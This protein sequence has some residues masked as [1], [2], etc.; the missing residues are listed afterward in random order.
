MICSIK[1]EK[2]YEYGMSM[3]SK[4]SELKQLA[5]QLLAGILANPHI[6]ASMSDE[7][8]RGQQEQKLIVMAIEMAESLIEKVEERID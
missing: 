1:K 5:A 8:G 4:V 3:D 6:Y 2:L 7:G